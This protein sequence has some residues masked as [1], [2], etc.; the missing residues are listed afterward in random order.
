V[1]AVT[2]S[3]RVLAATIGVSLLCGLAVS[4][5]PALQ[6]SSLDLRPALAEDTRTSTAGA[7]R[8]RKVLVVAELALGMVLLIGALLMIRT[9]LTL[10]PNAPGFDPRHKIVA[11]IRLPPDTALDEK[12]RFFEEV[13][14]QTLDIPGVRAVAGTTYLPMSRSVDI[15]DMSVGPSSGEVYTSTV[16]VNYLD[17][18]RIPVLRGRG[19]TGADAAGAPA[20][21]LV[22]EAFVRRWL[23][24]R[25]PL[26]ALVTLEGRPF[27]RT[28]ARIVGIVG[29]TRFA[30]LDVR[31]RPEV[32]LPFGQ[33]ILGNPYLVVSANPEALS[34]VPSTLRQI[35]ARVRPGQLV[36]RLEP[37]ET[38]LGEEVSR[39]RFAASLLGAFAALAVMLAAAG[40]G[41][42][43]AW[44]VAERRREIGVRIALGARPAQVGGLVLRQ[45]LSLSTVG[46]LIGLGAAAWGTRLLEGW[47]FGITRTD[48]PTYAACAVFML[49][50]AVGAAYVP[51]RRA[52]HVDPLE[53]LRG[54]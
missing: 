29:D 47:I 5:I 16:S 45:T 46:I 49:A 8:I 1:D 11:L 44:S 35:V 3:G 41:A 27:P 19:F 50:V 28:D 37:F 7:R 32:Y 39:P 53:A 48:P 21:A 34:A 40:L 36:D 26:G 51:A 2:L 23:S 15:L 9:F 33:A 31:P 43:L 38:M 10:R 12:Q 14:R 54:D 17:T 24:D 42:T 22:N 20:A 4:L 30:G 13:R 18:M 25:E 6:A 52:A